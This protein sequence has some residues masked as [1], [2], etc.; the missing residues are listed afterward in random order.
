M[1][2]RPHFVFEKM[3]NVA[4]TSIGMMG[5][6][7]GWFIPIAVHPLCF[8]ISN[9][10]RLPRVVDGQVQARDILKMSFAVFASSKMRAR[11]FKLGVFMLDPICIDVPGKNGFH[12]RKVRQVSP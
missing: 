11:V 2:R 7:D 4:I 5:R 12:I 9:I 8:G 1:L 6:V 10:S 3:G